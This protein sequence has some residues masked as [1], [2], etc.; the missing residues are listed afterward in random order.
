M[1]GALRSPT[2]APPSPLVLRLSKDERS[3]ASSTLILVDR[4]PIYDPTSPSKAI[5]ANSNPR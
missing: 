3:T 5:A 2:N 1:S 4:P